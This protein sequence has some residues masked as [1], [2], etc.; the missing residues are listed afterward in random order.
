[1]SVQEY[2]LKFT[3]LS[4]YAPEMVVDMRNMMS[5]FVFLLSY[6]SNKKGKATMLI[7]HMN[8]SRLMINVHQVER[9]KLK[10]L[11]YYASRKYGIRF[12]SPSYVKCGRTYTVE[13]HDVSNCCFMSGANLSSV[14]PYVAMRFDI[15][16]EQHLELFNVSTHICESIRVKIVYH[17]CI[18]SV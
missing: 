2:R 13:C 17:D 9:D 15:T 18:I 7:G 16:P 8:I 5:L 3:A 12:Q 6:L 1:M 14:T 11:G 10:S 4:C